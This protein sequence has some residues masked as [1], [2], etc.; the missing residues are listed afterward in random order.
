[1]VEVHES[2]LGSFCH[3]LC[4]GLSR[5]NHESSNM[6]LGARARR[7]VPASTLMACPLPPPSLKQRQGEFTARG[8]TASEYSPKEHDASAVLAYPAS[9]ST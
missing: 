2:R 9:H 6:T 7:P 3:R 8:A 1:M 4:A 5:N